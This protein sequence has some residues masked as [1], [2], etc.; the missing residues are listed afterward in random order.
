MK[1]YS[2]HKNP[3]RVHH[4][5]NLIMQ[6]GLK[7]KIESQFLRFMLRDKYLKP[8]GAFKVKQLI[9]AFKQICPTFSVKTVMFIRRGQVTK[10]YIATPSPI[11]KRYKVGMRLVSL[12]WHNGSFGYKQFYKKFNSFVEEVLKSPSFLKQTREVYYQKS[13]EKQPYK[14]FRW[15]KD[16]GSNFDT[17]SSS[18][19]ADKKQKGRSSFN[20]TL[21]TAGSLKK[22]YRKRELGFLTNTRGNKRH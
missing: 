16:N 5:T 14:H 20:T 8:E 15:S 4:F 22:L 18:I 10:N 1:R 7:E 6:R 13:L 12:A 9:E 17:V 2:F 19:S 21:G 3:Y 11:L